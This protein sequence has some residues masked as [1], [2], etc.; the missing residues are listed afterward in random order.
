MMRG[1]G[2]HGGDEVTGCGGCRTFIGG[3]ADGVA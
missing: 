1:R 3:R 2:S